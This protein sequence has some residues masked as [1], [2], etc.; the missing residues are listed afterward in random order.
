MA[1]RPKI[2]SFGYST[3]I[4][5][6]SNL[7]TK[8]VAVTLIPLYT[9]YLS[10]Y[11]VGVIALLEMLELFVVTIIPIGCVNAM[12]RYLSTEEGT[13]KNRIII[14][15]FA[16][17]IISGFFITGF[18]LVF[19]NTLINILNLDAKDNLLF[20]VLVSC[21]LRAISNFIYWLLQY[22]NK[23]ISYLILSLTQFISLIG[24]TI[25]F[26]IGVESGVIGIYY[27]K[28][29]VFSILLFAT[30][31]FLLKTV[32]AMPSI[33]LIKKLL[34]YG[35]P[36]IPLIL[37]MPVLTVS[38]RYFLQIYSSVEEIGRYGIAYKFGMLINMLLVVPIQKS[39]GPQMF[40]VG[41]LL[42][43]N[44]KIHQ[45]ITF[46]YSFIGL[47]IFLGLSLFSDT[48]LAIFANNDY[49]EVSWVIPWI[50]LAYFIGGFKI[51]LQASASLSDRTDLFIKTGF[52]T[53]LFNLFLNF[54]LIKH[55]GVIG[56]VSS[57]ILS[58]TMLIFLLYS[59]SRI[60]NNIKWPIKK[61]MHG[62]VITIIIIGIF[63]VIKDY[64]LE[65]E[66]IIKFVLLMLFP[67][68]SVFTKLIS[69][70]EIN[71][72]R[73]LWNTMVKKNIA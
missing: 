9:N 61:I 53:I 58:Y 24:L 64:N 56:A 7:L 71:G 10:V 3:I 1:I 47:F 30:I 20:Y 31:F 72:L 15:S 8:I 34:S 11:D 37:L 48:I 26:I 52:Y 39:W 49:I 60:V 44:K 22:K 5:G 43:E 36:I 6:F 19:K 73:Y 23:A 29:I 35:L 54:I 45:D 38:D 70:K 50:S 14:S 42:E 67:M 17:I 40:H 59:Y 16:I 41:D 2:K 66:I 68:I 55:F 4:Y 27:A 51:F 33:R 18:L 62:A 63:K 65:N 69:N 13:E 25:Y 28:I 21:F 57:T 46:Y 32:P 12:W